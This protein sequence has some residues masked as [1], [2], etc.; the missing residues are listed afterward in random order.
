[1]LHAAWLV[2]LQRRL[3]HGFLETRQVVL[4]QVQKFQRLKFFNGAIPI[5]K[6]HDKWR[7]VNLATYRFWLTQ[8]QLVCLKKQVGRLT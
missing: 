2:L 6:L 5:L 4:G 3:D 8:F 1:M 7:S